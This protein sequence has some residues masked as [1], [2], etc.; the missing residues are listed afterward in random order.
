V[1]QKLHTGQHFVPVEVESVRSEPA[2]DHTPAKGEK[3][4]KEDEHYGVLLSQHRSEYPHEQ[5]HYPMS[6]YGMEDRSGYGM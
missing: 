1:R 6:E 3:S 2:T 5:E 4:R